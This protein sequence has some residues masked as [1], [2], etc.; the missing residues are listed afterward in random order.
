MIIPIRSFS[1]PLDPS[2]SPAMNSSNTRLA[3]SSLLSCFPDESTDKSMLLD[4]SITI[5]MATPRLMSCSLSLPICGRAI[6]TTISSKLNISSKPTTP[7]NRWRTDRMFTPA[8]ST[9][10]NTSALP[11]LRQAQQYITT[12]GSSRNAQGASN[13]MASPPWWSQ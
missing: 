5:C 4:T 3:I 8:R 11:P 12:R 2:S 6:A 7:K 9:D 1:R 13:L 10:E